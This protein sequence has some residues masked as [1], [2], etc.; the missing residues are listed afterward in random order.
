LKTMPRSPLRVL[1]AEPVSIIAEDLRRR[2]ER[3]GYSVTGIAGSPGELD[4]LAESV[5][6]D[7]LLSEA[8]FEGGADGIEPAVRLSALRDVPL[9]FWSA[10]PSEDTVRRMIEASPEAILLK[11]FKERELYTTLDLASWQRYP[12]RLGLPYGLEAGTEGILIIEDE[13]IIAIDVRRRLERFGF[14]VVGIALDAETGIKMARALKPALITTGISLVGSAMDGI[15]V[16]E[17]INNYLDIPIIFLTA[18]TDERT[19]KRVREV[20]PE[21]YILKPFKERELMVTISLVLAKRARRGRRPDPE[22]IF[23]AARR[24][25]IADLTVA[26]ARLPF[27][28]Q[29]DPGERTPLMYAAARSPDPEPIRILA[30]A[31]ADLNALDAWGRTALHYAAGNG[32][33]SVTQALLDCGANPMAPEAEGSKPA[34]D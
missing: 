20:K 7:L 6:F 30:Q 10:D 5:D 3:F 18:F 4:R 15:E 23:A 14:P 33:V 28:D 22:G 1:I 13:K 2:L 25:N 31:G 26:V 16:A 24:G 9:V 32:S 17:A 8:V 12:N 21:A 11:P 29:R 27:P 19:L 34:A